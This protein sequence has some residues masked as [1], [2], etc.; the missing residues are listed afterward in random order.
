MTFA[1]ALASGASAEACE[2]AGFKGLDG[3]RLHRPVA[4]AVLSSFGMRKHPIL[5]IERLH[6]GLDLAAAPGDPVRA[7]AKGRVVFAAPS[8]EH[9]NLIRIDHGDG[10]ATAYAH[11]NGFNVK[12]GDC[13]AE[14]QV[15]GLAGATGLSAGS[16]LHFEVEIAGKHVD[17]SPSVGKPAR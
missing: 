16:Y 6:S 5:Q 1:L 10:L 15:I 4:G 9:G 7:A 17:P 11:L 14:G 12:M 8:G 2:T 13:V 3:L